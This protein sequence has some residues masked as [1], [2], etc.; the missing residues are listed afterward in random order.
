MSEF[1]KK[2][3]LPNMLVLDPFC[4]SCVTNIEATKLG[5]SSIGVD[6]NPLAILIG[7]V[8][9]TNVSF[10][11]V[12]DFYKDFIH[13]VEK[14]LSRYYNCEH[15][16]VRYC[17]H[18]LAL[19]C[20]SCNQLFRISDSKKVGKKYIC[21][22]CHSNVNSNLQTIES[23]YVVSVNTVECKHPIKDKK[24]IENQ[25]FLA[26]KNVDNELGT[27]SHFY[28]RELIENK[29]ILCYA[30]TTTSKFYTP[31]AFSALSYLADEIHKITDRSIKNIFLL[32]LT[33]TATQCSRLIPFRN[34]L[35]T[36]GPAW[37]VPGFWIPAMHLESNPLLNFNIRFRKIIKGLYNLKYNIRK[38]AKSV[39]YNMPIQ[40]AV[41]KFSKKKIGYIFA[42]PAYGDSVPYLEFSALWNTWLKEEP[43]YES[44]IV[45]SD[46]ISRNKKW[47]RYRIELADAVLKLSLSLSTKG[48]ITFTFNQL[49]LDAWHSLLLASEQANL[50]FD[51]ISMAL[52]AVIPAKAR[53]SERGS[54]IGDFYITFSKANKAKRCVIS[55]QQLEKLFNAVFQKLSASRKGIFFKPHVVRV[56]IGLIL[57]N[58]YSADTIRLAEQYISNSF[59]NGASPSIQYKAYV[60]GE[61]DKKTLQDIIRKDII[62]V[63]S[64]GIM[65]EW[66]IVQKI[67]LKY[68]FEEAPG[69]TEITSLLPDFCT[70]KGKS[71]TLK[72]QYLPSLFEKALL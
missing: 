54:Y 8:S 49:T 28:N 3:N 65:E 35:S 57:K 51:D 29:R 41:S 19:R 31:R 44:E 46:S 25:T 48:H 21:N 13:N 64:D 11:K 43:E 26:N 66:E 36:G 59:S 38:D 16:K 17:V 30:G 1:I 68:S 50:D 4:G 71:Y 12:E 33:S 58:K 55:Y 52:P 14:K 63:L 39:F 53:F 2:Y 15:G 22:S 24:I 10:A 40:K 27:D 6:I 67:L 42:D 69:V 56:V 60:P 61:G 62:E 9:T 47:G 72:S 23:S 34:E 70:K 45:V 32:C 5:I 7:K 37:S 20:S 18:Q